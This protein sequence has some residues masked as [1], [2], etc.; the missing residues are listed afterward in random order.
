MRIVIIG[1]GIAGITFAEKMHTLNPDA[2]I[3]VLTKDTDGY[4]SRPILSHGF[5]KK[6]IE[7]SIIMKTFAQLEQNGIHIISGIEV[8]A[9]DCKHRM[10]SISG[11]DDLDTLEYDKLILAQG[12]AAFIPPPFLAY[13]KQFYVFNSL[14]DLKLLRKF[15]QSL[16]EHNKSPGWAIIG[17]GLIGCELASDL[18]A[19]GDQVTI[20]HAM[21]RL[22]ERQLVAEDSGNLLKHFQSCGVNI[23]LD[24]AVQGFEH[25]G[26]KVSVLIKDT[27]E[28]KAYDAVIVSCGFKPRT[29]LAQDAGLE[30]SRGI[31]VNNFLQTNDENIYAL[32][33]VAQLPNEKIYAFIMPIRS[34]ALWLATYLNGDITEPWSPPVFNPKAK[35]HGFTAEH[36]Y[37][38]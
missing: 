36:P 25:Q 15:R 14:A 26:D 27:T 5:S 20:F 3:I 7:Q 10:L 30:T 34:Q 29:E 1:S 18:N 9:I 32:G 31:Q 24:Q 16:R 2:E 6:D 21:D 4:Y 28:N 19:A 38:F 23:L 8:T 22:M 33:D 17:G 13:R 11:T 35:V 12:S 37:I